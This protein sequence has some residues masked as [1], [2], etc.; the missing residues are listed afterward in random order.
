VE[1]RKES[2]F[3]KERVNSRKTEWIRERESKFEKERVKSRK[4]E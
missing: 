1:S 4:R 2:E 3:E